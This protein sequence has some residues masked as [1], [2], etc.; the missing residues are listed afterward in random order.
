MKISRR[1]WGD[2]PARGHAYVVDGYLPGGRRVRRQFPTRKAAEAYR[3]EMSKDI[4]SGVAARD[5]VQLTIAEIVSQ[6]ADRAEIRAREGE[7]ERATADN[8]QAHAEAI[9]RCRLAHVRADTARAADLEALAEAVRGGSIASWR[10]RF[11]V[12]RMA[13]AWAVRRGALSRNAAEGVRLAAPRAERQRRAR[14]P[15]REELRR[16]AAACRPAASDTPSRG[17]AFLTIA[18]YTAAR[19]SEVIALTL[20]DLRLDSNPSITIRRRCDRYGVV[21]PVKSDAAYREIPLGPTPARIL[22]RWLLAAPPTARPV[23]DRLGAP[24]VLPNAAG[25]LCSRSNL[26]RRVFVPALERAELVDAEGRALHRLH[27][28]R[29]AAASV[30]IDSGCDI[31]TVQRFMGHSSVQITLDTYGHLFRDD[32]VSRRL[33]SALESGFAERA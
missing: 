7:I 25:G 8:Y 15:G 2:G 32:Q 11:Q 33:T 24:L 5:A 13:L 16:L 31:K 1:E 22:R 10:N 28:L 23:I 18:L 9:W 6:F 14:V 27:D 12:V 20:D 21:G 29:H 30:L 26:R 19:V 17:E 4:A 3:A